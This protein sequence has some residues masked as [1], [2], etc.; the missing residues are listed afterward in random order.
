M[1][2]ESGQRD[3]WDI[4]DINE[5][6]VT[7]RFTSADGSSSE[8]TATFEQLSNHSAFPVGTELTQEAFETPAGSFEGT[9]AIFDDQHF[10]FSLAHPGP[11]IKIVSSGSVR[12]QVERTDL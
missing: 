11:P 8:D 6:S 9:H 7:T 3:T 10:Y 1:W 4:V 12:Q 5:H 2:E